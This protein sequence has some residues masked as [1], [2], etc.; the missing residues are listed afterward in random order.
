MMKV[1][2]VYSGPAKISVTLRREK[3]G[4][5]DY[6]ETRQKMKKKLTIKIQNYLKVKRNNHP[7]TAHKLSKAALTTKAEKAVLP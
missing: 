5:L 6:T 7:T 1:G 3:T 4:P 2:A